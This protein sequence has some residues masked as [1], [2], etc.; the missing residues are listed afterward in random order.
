M[1]NNLST[2]LTSQLTGKALALYC[3]NDHPNKEFRKDVS[4]VLY[5]VSNWDK[6]GEY[7]KRLIDENVSLVYYYPAFDS[8]DKTK[9]KECI[10]TIPDG[11]LYIG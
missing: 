1:K 5:A 8:E 7:I 4:M 6:A 10:G 3:L 9:G 2:P 11:A